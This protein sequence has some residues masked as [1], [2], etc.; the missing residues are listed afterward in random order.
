MNLGSSENLSNFMVRGHPWTPHTS[1]H[2]KLHSSSWQD[3]VLSVFLRTRTPGRPKR[4]M[5]MLVQVLQFPV[6]DSAACT[7]ATI[8]ND[9]DALRNLWSLSGWPGSR[10]MADSILKMLQSGKMLQSRPRD[11]PRH[12]GH[13]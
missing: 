12:C 4:P 11:P 1:I 5:P 2:D 10:G 9:L 3:D 8:R 13:H 6:V 7:G